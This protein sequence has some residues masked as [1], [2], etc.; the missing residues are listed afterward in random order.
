MSRVMTYA[1]I[2]TE[3][4]INRRSAEQLV[5]RKRWP[6]R[7]GNDGRARVEVPEDAFPPSRE[8]LS[9]ALSEAPSITLSEGLSEALSEAP[10]EAPS[11]GARDL[12]KHLVERLEAEV[13]ELRPKAD[14]LVAVKAMLEIERQ[15]VE[16]W[17]AVADRWAQ[18][19]EQ[20]IVSLPAPAPVVERRGLFGWLRRAG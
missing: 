3:F 6:R 10:S 11:E 8:A 12:L 16:E 18:Q 9:E 15:R 7:K 14:E 17:K 2:A 4:G 1:E 13:A 19:I 5:R 20:M